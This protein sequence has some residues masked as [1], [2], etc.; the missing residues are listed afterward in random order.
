MTSSFAKPPCLVIFAV[1][2]LTAFAGVARSQEG[3]AGPSAP[4]AD[5]PPVAPKPIEPG[6]LGLLTDD[7]QDAG[8][9]VRVMEAV[10]GSP[11][12]KAGLK[13]GDL[14][15][16]IDGKPVQSNADMGAAIGS[17]PPGSEVSFDID[18]DGQKQKFRVSLGQRPP[19]GERRFEQFGPVTE[20]L[21]PPSAPGPAPG[22]VS[23]EPPVL[24][25]PR[26]VTRGDAGEAPRVEL[27]RRPLLGVRTQTVTE[28]IRRRLRLPAASG[29][30]VA[31]RT[32]GSPAEK[33]GIPID[34]VI[35]A[36]NGA[37]VES[38]LDLARLISQA[39]IRAPV[40]ISYIFDGES[41]RA[42]V[43]LDEARN[44]GPV[45]PLGA[46]LPAAPAPLPDNP[47]PA[48]SDRSD[49]DALQHRVQELEERVRQLEQA[50]KK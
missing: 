37:P 38:P 8:K 13:P 40:E 46:P 27:G 15:T 12:E 44:S 41:R 47:A 26:P 5:A 36:V 28:D 22:P 43:V 29:A 50:A 42:K 24:G 16:G 18:R 21:P 19:V 17:L 1:W 2:F 3:S 10:G 48:N 14:I 7:R 11:A 31:S 30:L 35:V 32:L 45:P 23:G 4:K 34:S 33:A 6:Y 49:F 39:A 20:T 9:G 25:G